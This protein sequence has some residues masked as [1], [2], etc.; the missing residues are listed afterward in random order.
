MNATGYPIPEYVHYKRKEATAADRSGSPEEPDRDGREAIW[1]DAVELACTPMRPLERDILRRKNATLAD[2]YGIRGEIDNAI[3]YV[4][5]L[6][7]RGD[8]IRT[9]SDFRKAAAWLEKYADILDADVRTRLVDHLQ[10]QSVKLGH[11][12][13]LTEKFQWDRWAGRDP[14][15]G[16]VREF[17]ENNLH[18]LATGSVF[19]TDQF[20][21]LS[22]DEMRECLPDMLKA[23][24]LGM[25]VIQPDRIGKTA[26]ALPERDARIL[27]ALLE[28]HGQSPV[29]SD[30]GAPVEINDA[31]LAAL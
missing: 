23:A 8:G 3:A 9:V 7:R 29:H 15:T 25:D 19:R 1:L 21:V 4:E 31:V 26:S 14:L 13:T 11:L 17:A 18:K 20:A 12:P 30:Y 2:R 16:E 27:E 5:G 28:S 22:T 24:S 6:G 10:E